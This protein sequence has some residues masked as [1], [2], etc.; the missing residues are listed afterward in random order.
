[1]GCNASDGRETEV[2]DASSPVLVDQYVRLRRL[3][4]CKYGDISFEK[5]SY[6]FQ[7]SVDNAEIMH[8]PQAI[9]DVDQLNGTSAWLL[10][11]QM[12][13]YELGPVYVPLPLDELIDISIFHPLGNHRIPVFADCRSKKW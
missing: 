2:G 10:W 4:G 5:K 8:I 13:P 3:T 11:N 9:R 1:M 12:I 7:I 6:P